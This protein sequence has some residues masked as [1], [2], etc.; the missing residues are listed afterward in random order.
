MEERNEYIA[1]SFRENDTQANP[2]PIAYEGRIMNWSHESK[3]LPEE[4]E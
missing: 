2:G 1:G 4:E 3:Y